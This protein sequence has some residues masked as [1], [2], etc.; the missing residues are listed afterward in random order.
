[1]TF[2]LALK[3]T[4]VAAPPGVNF[5]NYAVN[6]YEMSKKYL[7]IIQLT[8]NWDSKSNDLLISKSKNLIF[9]KNLK[10]V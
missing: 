1:M 6:V 8:F 2:S 5:F 10:N 9:S 3:R 4:V 7:Y